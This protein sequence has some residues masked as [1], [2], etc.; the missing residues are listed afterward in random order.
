M[1]SH[2]YVVD[3]AIPADE[4]RRLYAGTAHAVVARDRLSG[5]SV[6][7][8]AS[9][10]RPFVTPAGVHGRFELQVTE[11]QRLLDIRALQQGQRHV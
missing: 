4:F 2:T 6:R 9:R 1:G 3:L 8:P 7:F 11:D 10:L 5:R